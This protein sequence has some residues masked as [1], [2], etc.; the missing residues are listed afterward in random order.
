M[1]NKIYDT[2]AAGLPEPMPYV[3]AFEQLGFGMFVHFGLYSL[4]RRG[5]WVR[6]IEKIPAEEYEPLAMKFKP[7]SMKDIVRTAKAA[8]C[9]Y[10]TLTTRHHDGFSLYDTRGLDP[11]DPFDAVHT[12]AGRDLIAEFVDE[13]RKA[14]IV[15]FFY[16]T[17][18]DWHRPEFREDFDAYLEY[19]EKSVRILCENYGKIGGFWFDGNWSKPDADWH[20]DRLYK[21]IRKL[22]P[23]AMIINNTGMEARGGL[24][25]SEID[26][27]TYERGRPEPMDRTGQPKYVSAEMCETL[28]DHWGKAANDIDFKSVRQLIEELCECRKVGAN[29]L[30]NVG[31]DA[32]GSIDAMQRATMECIGAWMKVYGKAIYNGRPFLRYSGM[33]EFLLRDVKDAGTAY[34]FKFDPRRFVEVEL[35]AGEGNS[36]TLGR[37]PGRV[38]SVSWMDNGEQLAFK[39][40]GGE[41]TVSLTPFPYGTSYPVRVAEM[42]FEQ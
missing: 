24:G 31:P 6:E 42:K 16:H 1:E 4:L 8:G 5:E 7:E 19:L 30:L 41:V 29:F 14:D 3:A 23:E 34:L 27:V 20:E 11:E 32:D 12:G 17:T 33:R 36:L 35:G 25:R 22:Q 9:R 40:E 39:Q 28:C 13:C 21:Q 10:V 26:A 38:R 37:I 18:L 15:P 2:N